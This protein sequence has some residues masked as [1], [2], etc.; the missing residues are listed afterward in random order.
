MKALSPERWQQINTLLDHLFDLP[1]DQHTAFLE[2]A[3]RDQ[4]TLY[5]QL[6]D[7]LEAHHDDGLPLLDPL[8]SQRL[9]ALINTINP[10]LIDQALDA[11]R[12]EPPDR[13]RIGPYLLSDHLGHGGM[14]QVFLAERADGAFHKKVALKLIRPGRDSHAVERR[15]LAERQI[16][17]RLRHEHIAR[18]LDGG[19]TDTGQPFFVM[20]FVEGTRVTDYCD[21]HR[22]SIEERLGLFAQVCRA[23]HYA[24][25]NLVVHRDLKPSNILVTTEGQVKLLDF[26]IAKVLAEEDEALP[27]TTLTGTG[28]AVMTPAYAAPEQVRGESV[29]TATDIYALGLL[30]YEMLTG[31]RAYEVTGRSQAELERVI[32]GEEPPRP[33]TKV[34]QAQQRTRGDGTTERLTPESVSQARSLSPEKLRQRL[35]GDL[36]TMVLKALK[37]EPERRYPSAEAFLE[38]VKRHLA[39]LPVSAQA[40]TLG[41]RLRKFVGRHRAAVAGVAAVVML[42]AIVVGFYTVRVSTERNRAQAEA[43]K[44]EEVKEYLVGLFE[45]S[46]PRNAESR[47]IKA[48]ELLERGAERIETLAEEP[49]IQAEMMFVLGTV[50]QQM[51]LYDESLSMHEQSLAIRQNILGEVHEDV[52]HSL[53]ALAW[54]QQRKGD[55]EAAEQLNRQALAVRRALWKDDH[56]EIAKS[57]SQLGVP[58][59]ILGKY[60]EAET[61]LREGLAMNEKLLGPDHLNTVNTLNYLGLLLFERRRFDEAEPLLQR[62]L[63]KNRELLGPKHPYTLN[64]LNNLGALYFSTDQFDKAEP[65]YREAVEASR[66]VYGEEHPRVSSRLNNLGQLLTLIDEFDE[67]EA[68]L[69]EA[70]ALSRKLRGDKHMETAYCLVNLG[71]LF[72]RKESYGEAEPFLVEALALLREIFPEGHRNIAGG[73]YQLG[74]VYLDQG[75]PVEAE[76]LLREALTIRREVYDEGY[77]ATLEAQSALGASLAALGRYDEAEPLLLESLAALENQDNQE[78]IEQTRQYLFDLYTA[79]GKPEQ[80]AAYQ[81]ESPP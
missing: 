54:V 62:A 48:R 53:H 58:L 61:I 80:A 16:L 66:E 23:V 14:G 15:F 22:L 68:V 20:E 41:Y 30:L 73:A 76:P 19:V 21:E 67:A 50:F 38:D 40:D 3:C 47:D 42:L 39:G 49:E 75:R 25:R 35:V 24:H 59:I 46:D 29:T 60:D 13:R 11:R 77:V 65:L 9:A 8:D 6:Q 37:K 4:P 72:H 5:Q 79:W 71:V 36:D 57:L 28:Q 27:E 33:S 64:S 2:K 1:P 69:R 51:G 43:S 10:D 56:E 45:V 52:A 32:C 81:G 31:H 74:L 55:Y 70:L 63:T 12:D 26:G 18:L 78:I 7:A 17:A 34:S 44:L